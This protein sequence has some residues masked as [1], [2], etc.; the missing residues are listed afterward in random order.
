MCV[1]MYYIKSEYKYVVNP[2]GEAVPIN[3]II[4][5]ASDVIILSRAAKLYTKPQPLFTA[6]VYR[7]GNHHMVVKF[8]AS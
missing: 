5:I 2:R 7:A 3:H 6:V 8:P 1:D 4:V